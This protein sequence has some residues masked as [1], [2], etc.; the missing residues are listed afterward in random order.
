[1]SDLT[2]QDL[3]GLR[4]SWPT[5]MSIWSARLTFSRPQSPLL[6]S[7]LV[8]QVVCFS[9]YALLHKKRLAFVATAMGARV[10]IE[11]I[12]SPSCL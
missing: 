2:V 12:N 8:G 9:G 1:M 5:C 7:A 6:K 4:V 3:C 10:G 11:I